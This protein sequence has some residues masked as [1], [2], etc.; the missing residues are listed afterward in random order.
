MRK[1]R[2]I[3]VVED[4]DDDFAILEMCLRSAG[5]SNPIDRCTSGQEVNE[6]LE[7]L[8]SATLNETPVF[9]FLDLNLPGTHGLTVLERLKQH[10]VVTSTPVAV[11]TTS[12]QQRD[13]DRSYQL[14]AAGFLTKPLDLDKFERMIQQVADYWFSCVK[15]PASTDLVQ[16]G[17]RVSPTS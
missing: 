6:Y 16:P 11:L 14:G 4:S 9:G 1:Q 5:V 7:K 8:N 15:L 10:P 12:A 2:P 17:K 13:I 3:L